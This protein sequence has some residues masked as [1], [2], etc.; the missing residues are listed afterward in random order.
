M[1]NSLKFQWSRDLETDTA[2]APGPAVSLTSVAAYGES[3]AVPRE[4]EPD[5]HRW[6]FFDVFSQTHGK[7]TFKAGVD[8]SS[9]TRS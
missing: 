8:L 9:S 5:E 7:H 1:A 6:Q 4:A 2:N 3:I